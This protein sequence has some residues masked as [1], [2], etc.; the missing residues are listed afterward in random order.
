MTV[1]CDRVAHVKHWGIM[2]LPARSAKSGLRGKRAGKTRFMIK[3]QRQN[4]EQREKQ[5]EKQR[6]G[7]RVEREKKK[8]EGSKYIFKK[9]L[10]LETRILIFKIYIPPNLSFSNRENTITT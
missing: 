3:F 4:V 9:I 2:R 5:R 6:K 1:W 8:G 7:T 10:N